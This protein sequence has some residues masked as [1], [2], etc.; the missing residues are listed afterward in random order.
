MEKD[1]DL[2][3]RIKKGDL[4]AFDLLYERYQSGLFR[5]IYGYLKCKEDAEEV[6]HET[7]MR[8]LHSSDIDFE[9]GTF[10]GWAYQVARN[11]SL[12][13]LRTQK[14]GSAALSNLDSVPVQESVEHEFVQKDF[15]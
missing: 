12:N 9:N 11:L 14:R 6:F 8:V 4:K 10:R 1:E 3:Y 13:R 2:Y 5:F 15:A 7:F